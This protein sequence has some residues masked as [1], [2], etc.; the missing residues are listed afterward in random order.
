MM[1]TTEKQSPSLRQVNIPPTS[2][3]GV[4]IRAGKTRRNYIER[5]NIAT[6][7]VR[8]MYQAGKLANVILEAKRLNI[9]VIGISEVGW[10]GQ[11]RINVDGYEL[12]YSGNPDKHEHGVAIMITSELGKLVNDVMPISE[13]VIAITLDTKPKPITIIQ[14]YA[15]TADSEDQEVEEMYKDI[16]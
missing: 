4:T 1:N 8:S 13:R 6:W 11:N 2:P 16:G 9:D 15:P 10:T 12:I 5:L 14:I 3:R 7:N